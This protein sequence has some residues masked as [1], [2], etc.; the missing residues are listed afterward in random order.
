VGA[1]GEVF[2]LSV[3]ALRACVVSRLRGAVQPAP[4]QVTRILPSFGAEKAKVAVSAFKSGAIAAEFDAMVCAIMFCA[5]DVR[6]R[7]PLAAL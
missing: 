5:A 6:E 7:E 1:V 3:V 4:E 2:L